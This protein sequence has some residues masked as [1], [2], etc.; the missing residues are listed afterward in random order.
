MREETEILKRF[1][2]NFIQE[3]KINKWKGICPILDVMEESEGQIYYFN[4][5]CY[6]IGPVQA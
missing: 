5:Y 4:H 3:G 6:I 2:A 1:K